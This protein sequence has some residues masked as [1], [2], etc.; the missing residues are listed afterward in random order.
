MRAPVQ[1]YSSS[2]LGTTPAVGR[3]HRKVDLRPTL[4][5]EASFVIVIERTALYRSMR[6]HPYTCAC[7]NEVFNLRK[8]ALASFTGH[9]DDQEGFLLAFIVGEFHF[10]ALC[11]LYLEV[12]DGGFG[13]PVRPARTTK[14]YGK[15]SAVQCEQQLVKY[16][17]KDTGTR[18]SGKHFAENNLTEVDHVSRRDH[19]R[20]GKK[21]AVRWIAPFLQME[22]LSDK[23]DRTR[24]PASTIFRKVHARM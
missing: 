21:R 9:V 24:P 4:P 6:S 1:L 11:I 22:W 20:T 14:P 5:T 15:G 8:R 10:D 13:R 2:C 7:N 16:L 19:K 12:E 18:S 23:E 3:P 17:M